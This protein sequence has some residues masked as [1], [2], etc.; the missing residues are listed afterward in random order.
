MAKINLGRVVGTQGPKGERGERGPQGPTGAVGP[1]GAKGDKGDT[2]ATGATGAR[3]PQGLQGPKGEQGLRGA[4]GPK[5]DRGDT[6]PQGA[7]GP[8][9]PKGDQGLRGATGPAGPNAVSA[10]TVV[11]GF[12]NGQILFNNNGR[13]GAK[14]V[15]AS[16]VGAFAK[17][18]IIPLANG[19]TGAS[20]V[21]GAR[22]NLDLFAHTTVITTGA[23]GRWLIG[24][25]PNMHDKDILAVCTPQNDILIHLSVDYNTRRKG[26]VSGV[27]YQSD[28]MPLKSQPIRISL[29]CG[30]GWEKVRA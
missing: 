4:T 20:D 5:G 23:D 2:G 10:T 15:T 25:I 6:G 22:I 27:A 21:Y 19:G 9:G 14:A 18:E 30:V 8:A 17:N 1:A 3:G 13:V 16:S 7:T 24:T 29:V 28:N 26:C 11:S 12:A